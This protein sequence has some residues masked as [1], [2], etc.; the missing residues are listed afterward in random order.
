[1]I[2]YGLKDRVIC[3]TG[4]ASGIG[5]AAALAAAADG[6]HVAVIDQRQVDIDRV[7]DEIRAHGVKAVGHALDVRDGAA[8]RA[9]AAAVE[10]GL[11]PVWGLFCSAGIS[12]TAPAEKLAEEDFDAVMDVNV[13]GVVLSCREFGQAMIARGRGAIVLVGSIDGLGG[14]PGRIHY[15][16]SKFAVAGVTKNLALEWGRHGVRVNSVMPGFVDTPLLRANMPEGYIR[17]VVFDRTPLGRMA[18]A[19]EIAAVALMMMSDG[20]SY[21]NGAIVPVDG[22]MTAGYLTRAQGGDY[23]SMALLRDG[24]YTE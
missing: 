14:H 7:L 16:S 19:A 13:K 23:A 21:M 3:I 1:M 24:I 8:T 10:A 18:Q 2:S 20:A 9:A 5:R 22:G 12:R 4:G 17:N 6:A 11:G 15:V